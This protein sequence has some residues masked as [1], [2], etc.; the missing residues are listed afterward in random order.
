MIPEIDIK[1]KCNYLLY[2]DNTYI[3]KRKLEKLT[4][5][6]AHMREGN[7]HCVSCVQYV[8]KRWNNIFTQ[9]NLLFQQWVIHSDSSPRVGNVTH[10][11]VLIHS[12]F[13]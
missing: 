4:Y 12:L 13:G 1:K 3:Q 7:C 6:H 11:L 5:T 10:H 8:Q 9:S 2:N